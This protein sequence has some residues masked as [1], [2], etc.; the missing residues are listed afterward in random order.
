MEVWRPHMSW[1][2][3]WL[4]RREGLGDYLHMPACACCQASGEMGT[5]LFRCLQCGEFC[6]AKIACWSDIS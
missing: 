1:F 4:L 3:D 2:L 5:R 6:S